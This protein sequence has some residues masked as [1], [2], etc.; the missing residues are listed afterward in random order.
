M[1]GAALRRAVGIVPD[2]ADSAADTSHADSE[3]LQTLRRVSRPDLPPLGTDASG[4]ARAGSG[5]NAPP[6]EPTANE[7]LRELIADAM[8]R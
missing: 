7:W 5:R 8:T 3:W 1:I 2:A 4:G 6:R